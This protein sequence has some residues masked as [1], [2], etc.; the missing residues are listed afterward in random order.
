MITFRV[1]KKRKR[2]ERKKTNN[3]QTKSLQTKSKK[4]MIEGKGGKK[5]Q[6]TEAI[7]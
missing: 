4:K 2:K 3:F 6:Q 5:A 7:Q 1:K